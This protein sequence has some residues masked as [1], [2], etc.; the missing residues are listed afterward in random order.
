M[1]RDQFA[2]DLGVIETAGGDWA[3]A[4]GDLIERWQGPTGAVFLSLSVLAGRSQQFAQLHH[5]IYTSFIDT[6]VGGQ[7]PMLD[8]REARRRARLAT[9]LIDGI[10]I[11]LRPSGGPSRKDRVDVIRGAV[12]LAVAVLEQS[13]Q[14]V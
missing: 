2:Q 14:Q 6:L 5:D 10:A 11:Q 1:I 3:R 4:F 9:A 12:D 13:G 7:S 8:R